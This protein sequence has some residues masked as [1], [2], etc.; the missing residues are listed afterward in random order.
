MLLD[1]VTKVNIANEVYER[2]NW[3]VESPEEY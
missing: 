3:N 1:G 2:M